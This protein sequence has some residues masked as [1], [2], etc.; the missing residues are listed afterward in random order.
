MAKSYQ[1]LADKILAL[2]GGKE[3]IIKVTHCMTRLRFVLA[4]Q[5]QVNEQELTKLDQVIGVQTS[6]DQFQIIIGNDVAFVYEALVANDLQL[7][8]KEKQQQPKQRKNL[9]MRIVDAISGSMSPFIVA[10]CAAGLVKVLL[11][12]LPML[13][14]I[15]EESSTFKVLTVIGDGA[16]YFLPV[17]VAYSSAVMFKANPYIAVVVA[18]ILIHPDFVALMK[19]EGGS[20]I[21]GIPIYH[22]SYA[23]SIIPVLLTTFIMSYIERAVDKI[24]PKITKNFLNPFV[25]ML[26]TAILALTLTGPIGYI[27]STWLSTGMEWMNHNFGWFAVTLLAALTPFIV[28]TGLHHALGPI[29]IA[30]VASLGY[31]AFWMVAQLCS[32]LS[33][34]GASLAAGIRLKDRAQKSIAYSAAISALVGGVTEPALFG[35]TLKYKRPLLACVISSGVAGLFAAI[36]H[37]KSFAIA[38]LALT[39][40][41]MWMS[42]EDSSNLII[43]LITIAISIGLSFVLTLVFG[44]EIKEK[45]KENQEVQGQEESKTPQVSGKKWVYSPMQGEVRALDTVSDKAFGMMGSGVAIYPEIGE[46]RAP[47]NGQV[48]TVTKSKHAIA[49]V[50]DEGI[51]LLIHIGLDT[52]K[53]K[54]EYFDIEVEEGDSV[55]AG[56]LLIRFDLEKIREAGYD[57]TTP[58]VVTNSASYLDVIPTKAQRIAWQEKLLTLL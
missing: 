5:K 53:L 11:I 20:S 15:T 58:I 51:E 1:P 19:N 44:L 57:L 49:L 9:I 38:N 12:L 23:Y 3:N 50:S 10:L 43:A 46:V 33:Q 27:A 32:N 31:D 40:I 14:L 36:M 37:L 18:G 56:D 8:D 35:V 13:G 28:L 41:P 7:T 48:A 4:D 45:N 39:T 52:V 47:F 2:V 55:N 34:G 6:G 16:F 25:I 24:L 42:P 29:A 17:L 22:A 54:G 30:N 26:I 21:F